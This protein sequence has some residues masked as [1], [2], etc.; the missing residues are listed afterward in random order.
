MYVQG[1]EPGFVQGVLSLALGLCGGSPCERCYW[2]MA[3]AVQRC[4]MVFHPAEFKAQPQ[5]GGHR[6]QREGQQCQQDI[7]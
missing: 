2:H 4:C 3:P 5:H 1:P 6:Q 7:L